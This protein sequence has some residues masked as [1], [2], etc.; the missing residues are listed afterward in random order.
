LVARYRAFG[1]YMDQYLEVLQDGIRDGRT[2]PRIA[3]ERVLG[4]LQ[5][6]LARPVAESTLA[7]PALSQPDLLASE[8]RA[9]VADV[10]YPSFKRMLVFLED[11]LARH[12]RQEPGIWA[13]TDGDQI[14]MLLARQH[15][16]TELSP[17]ELH[18]FGLDDL[19]TIHGEMRDIIRRR[20]GGAGDISI[21][22]F[23]E[24]LIQDPSNLPSG[25]E[26][27]LQIAQQLL[28]AATAALPRAFGRLPATPMV[29]KPI[30]EYRERDAPAAFYFPASP[31]GSRPG[32]FYINTFEPSSRPKHTLP[33]LAFHEGVPGHHLQIGLAQETTGL[34]AFRRL[35]AGWLA[36]A[37]VEGWALYTERLA[38]D[39][40]LYPD[41]LARYGM[42]GYQ[43]WRACRL[44]VD[45][46][47]HHL[48]WSRQ[49]AIDFFFENVG[50]SER[51]TV[52]EVDRYIVWPGQALSYKVGQREIEAVRR[53][54]SE[55]LGGSF[56]LRAF[57]DQLLSH[58]GV[59]LSTL[60]VLFL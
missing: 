44:V 25:R 57:H 14:Y 34:P 4:Q 52:N 12:A 42:L 39:L 8:L 55:R 40:G 7:A 45:T 38:D 56:D 19:Q 2:A 20:S 50:L 1:V 15:T 43:A 53:D 49:R 6:L 24:Q 22:A 37:F 30:E 17:D 48:R 29:V 16:T 21:R 36:N 10:V 23:T 51:E 54:Q 60:R 9:A 47:L 11:Y 13:V 27:L 33:A 5:A 3:A 31:D 18:Q 28:D 59:P 58:A 32:T 41:D 35:S 26:E 46:G